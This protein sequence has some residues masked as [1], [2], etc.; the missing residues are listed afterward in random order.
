[1]EQLTYLGLHGTKVDDDAVAL[2]CK[3]LRRLEHIDLSQCARVTS[4][5]LL[6]LQGQ[7]IGHT[8]SRLAAL[9]V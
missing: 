4:V 9:A 3:H 8:N 5:A 7:P 2:V 6:S 1:M